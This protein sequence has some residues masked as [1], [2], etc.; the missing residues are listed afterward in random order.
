MFNNFFSYIVGRPSKADLER[1]RQWYYNLMRSENNEFENE[2]FVLR[3]NEL[4]ILIQES[5][6]LYKESFASADSKVNNDNF[7]NSIL[8]QVEN[9][10]KSIAKIEAR[11]QDYKERVK[12]RNPIS[13]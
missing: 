13:T 3:I 9:M 12:K 7:R 6:K 10:E 11:H 1:S 2:T 4:R 5:Y 8:Q